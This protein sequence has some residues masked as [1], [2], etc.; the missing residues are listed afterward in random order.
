M[1]KAP[2][3]RA[4]GSPPAVPQALATDRASESA[5]RVSRRP[6]RPTGR[7]VLADRPQLL[8][9][10]ERAIRSAGPDV[11]ME[12]IAAAATVTKPILYR[13]V[14]D[15]D[16]LVSALAEIF[17]DRINDAATAAAARTR[18][19]RTRLRSLV[20]AYI[21]VVD[22]NRNLYLFVTAGGTGLDRVSQ[23]L[24]LADRSALPLARQLAAQRTAAGR[25]PAVAMSWAFGFIGALHFAT[26]A[27]LRD[28]Q[29]S[30]GQLVEHITELLWCGVGGNPT[31]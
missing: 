4:K 12:A 2:I 7:K 19:P 9:A 3:S 10:A 29:L 5:T 31:P 1:P 22:A 13:T 23:V 24:L 18:L 30:A 6:G 11:T 26:L 14:G 8:A 15:R 21:S 28:E 20:S 16:A 27:W 17:V 25:D